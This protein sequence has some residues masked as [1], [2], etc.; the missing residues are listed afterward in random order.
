MGLLDEA[1][2]EHLELK[3]RRG[4]DP[5]EIAREE[6]EALAPVFGEAPVAQ[7]PAQEEDA[8]P[9]ELAAQPPAEQPHA[10]DF[11]SVGQ[12]TAE[13]DMQSVLGSE[14]MLT[15]EHAAPEPGPGQERLSFE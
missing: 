12:E 11:S 8:A 13:L 2:R 15:E 10:E 3:R 9:A 7:A 14:E 5:S 4:G 1:I 6:H